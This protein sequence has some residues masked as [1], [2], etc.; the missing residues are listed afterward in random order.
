RDHLGPWQDRDV[1]DFVIAR[2]PEEGTSLPFLV[3]LPLGRDGVVLKTRETWPRTSKLYC[4]QAEWPADPEVIERVPVRTCTRRGA[5]I[6]LVLDRGRENRSQF[7]FARGRGR[8][9]IFWQTASVAK[10]ARPNV[11]LPTARASGQVLQILVDSHERYA[12]RFA[13]Q[14]ATVQ[15]RALPAGD[16]GVE[17]DGRLVGAVERKSLSDLASSLTSGKLRHQAA[18]LASLPR[19]A[20]VVEDRYSRIFAL[21]FVRPVVVAEALAELQ[22][23]V[24]TVPVVFAETRKLAQEW[25]YRFLGAALAHASEEEGGAAAL[26]ALAPAG[27]LPRRD[28]TTAEIRTWAVEAGLDV[29]DRGRI[30]AD[31]RAA[32]DRAHPPG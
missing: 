25:T 14:Q 27:P 31:V 11:G 32:Y 28:P 1:D 9:M 17:V 2:N 7:V 16:Y 10:Q 30:A 8:Q 23:R 19:A 21:T 3:R 18:E 6:D 12:W 24:P 22:V 15:K 5:A 20:I 13:D 29:S 4:H 26:A